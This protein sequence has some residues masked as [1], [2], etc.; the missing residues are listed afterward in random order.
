MVESG[1]AKWERK[2]I[3]QRVG[4]AKIVTKTGLGVIGSCLLKM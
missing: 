1:E 2:T 4:T 3:D